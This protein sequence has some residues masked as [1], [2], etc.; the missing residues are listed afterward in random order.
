MRTEATERFQ[1]SF[2]IIGIQEVGELAAKLIMAVLVIPF[3][4]R[5]FDCPVH[6]FNLAVGP[7][8]GGHGQAMVY[9]IRLANQI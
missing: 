2:E 5:C 1:S 8:M 3:D 6:P 9:A 7:R 4:R